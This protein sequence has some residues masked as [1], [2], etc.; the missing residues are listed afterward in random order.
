MYELPSKKNVKSIEITKESVLSGEA[1]K[2]TN[3]SKDDKPK[4]GKEKDLAVVKKNKA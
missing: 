4:E 2:I 1:P 3:F